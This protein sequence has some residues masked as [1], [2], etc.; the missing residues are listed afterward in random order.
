M[1]QTKREWDSSSVKLTESLLPDETKYRI[2]LKSSK[3]TFK[4]D[5]LSKDQTLEFLDNTIKD[6]EAAK[7]IVNAS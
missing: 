3:F 7:K 4:D 6:L 1:Q 5:W 2:D